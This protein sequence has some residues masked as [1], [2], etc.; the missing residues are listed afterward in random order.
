MKKLIKIV[1]FV[2]ILFGAGNLYSQ[3]SEQDVNALRNQ[4][5]LGMG[6]GFD[7]GGIG[8]KFEYLPVKHFGLF[9]G[10]GHN[11]LGVGYNAGIT[12]KILPDKKNSPNIIA[13]YGYNATLQVKG[14]PPGKSLD[15]TSYGITIGINFDVKTKNG[16][17]LSFGLFV[18]FRSS[19]FNKKYDEAS[20]ISDV[21]E[22]LPFAL[23]VGYNFKL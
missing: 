5:Y 14:L 1:C 11:F 16:D 2:I 19:K 9:G 18:P 12:Y 13:F 23:S 22:L 3:T 15:A 4:I 7:Y 8:V 6:A 17:K 10:F 21:D 20:Q